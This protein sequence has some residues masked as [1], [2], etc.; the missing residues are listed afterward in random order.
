MNM[1]V[2]DL[3]VSNQNICDCNFNDHTGVMHWM[4]NRITN[5]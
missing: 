3:A 5:Q 4:K 1:K 2:D